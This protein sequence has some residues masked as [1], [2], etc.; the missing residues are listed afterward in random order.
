MLIPVILAGG[1]GTRLWPL[2]RNSQ[3]KQFLTLHGQH[4]LLVQ[5]CQRALQVPDASAPLIIGNNEHRFMIAEQLR[6]AQI[7][8]MG[9][10]LEPAGRSTAPAAALAA[11]IAQQHSGSESPLL[12]ILPADHAIAD[13]TA[14]IDVVTRAMPL[15]RAGKLVTFGIRP[16]MAHTGYGY[17]ERGAAINEYAWQIAR[18]VEKPDLDTA[19]QYLDSQRFDW[20]SGMFLMR[21]DI[22]LDAMSAHAGD[23]LE[24]VSSSLAQAQHDADFIRP[25]ATIWQSCRSD[26]IDYAIMEHTDQGAVLPLDAG[27][28]DIGA[29]QALWDINPKTDNGNVISGD[30]LTHDSHNN[31]LRAE[32]RLVATVGVSHLVVVETADAVLIASR[33]RS[34]EVKHIVNQLKADGRSEF[35]SHLRVFRPWG[36]YESV[37]VGERHQ[38]KRIHV[39]PGASLSLQRHF[40]RSEH[41]VVVRGT[42]EV[43]R[44]SETLLLSENQSA[45]IPVTEVHRLRN[46][47]KLPLEI[48]EVQTGEYLGEDD[49]QRLEDTYGRV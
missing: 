18:F 45:Y 24:A 32:H 3:P 19:Q 43:V 6:Q 33:E 17:I 37:D 30:V 15:A 41:W 4:S 14:F 28:N 21:A 31:Y 23:I 2:S 22:L 20:N 8:P 49:I 27:W 1:S 7:H 46:P 12:L 38:V 29:W 36:W 48:V 47:G 16:T 39:F 42:A 5:T 9:I 10:A 40:H 34:E 44:G 25:D 13:T 26:S 11:R 35:Q